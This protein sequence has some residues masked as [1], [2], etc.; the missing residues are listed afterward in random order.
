MCG[1]VCGWGGGVTSG[2]RAALFAPDHGR[3]LGPVGS[4]TKR[5]ACDAGPTG[6]T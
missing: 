2:I 3:L 4:A 5:A 6:I 1:Y